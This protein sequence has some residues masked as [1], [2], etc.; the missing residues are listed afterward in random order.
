MINLFGFLP[1]ALHELRYSELQ[2]AV[3]CESFGADHTQ[4]RRLGATPSSL[5]LP[6][7]SQLSQGIKFHGLM[8]YI[9]RRVFPS[10]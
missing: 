3:R 7:A 8:I 5:T 4:H 10:K 9:Y 1:I 6:I 2:V